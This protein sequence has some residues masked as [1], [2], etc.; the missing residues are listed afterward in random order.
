MRA[1]ESISYEKVLKKLGVFTLK[2]NNPEETWYLFSNFWIYYV[3]ET[4][5]RVVCGRDGITKL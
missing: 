2:R 3:K 1:L 4:D 5:S